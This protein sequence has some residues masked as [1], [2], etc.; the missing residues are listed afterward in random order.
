MLFSAL[1]PPSSSFMLEWWVL[2]ETPMRRLRGSIVW[3]ILMTVGSYTLAQTE[4]SKE[5]FWI[6]QQ[7]RDMQRDYIASLKKRLAEDPNNVERQLDLGRVYF[8][9]ALYREP[10]AGTEAEKIFNQILARDP[11][12][13]IALAYHGAL[14]GV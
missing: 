10:A 7:Y 9:L 1:R 12:N 3:I 13:A 5:P 4:N 2:S 11:H 14:L 8:R 6:W